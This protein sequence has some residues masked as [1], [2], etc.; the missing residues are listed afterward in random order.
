[1]HN[2]VSLLQYDCL[3]RLMDAALC[4]RGPE[5]RMLYSWHEQLSP[6]R[7]CAEEWLRCCPHELQRLWASS[8][9]RGLDDQQL[10]KVPKCSD[11][12]KMVST[13]FHA[14]PQDPSIYTALMP[15]FESVRILK[16]ERVEN[17][18]QEDVED[19]YY[20][21]LKKSLEKQ[22]VEFEPGMHTRWLFH[23]TDAIESIISNPL[24]GFQPL[25]SGGR[26][27][28]VWGSGT[29]FARDAE[30][31]HHGHFCKPRA[32]G[33]RQMLMC[34][35]MTGIPCLGG[36]HQKGVLPFRHKPY[37]YNSAVDSLSNPEIFIVQHPSAAYPAYL[38]T[39]A[40]R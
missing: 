35:V 29:Y 6:E 32:D 39:Y 38:I 33:S 14:E 16:V 31:V 13:I 30:Y 11:E 24:A 3:P 20:M 22:G 7:Q 10:F 37:R 4:H 28:S 9:H 18:L 36:E 1:M 15:G 34:L 25:T 27:G 23:G 8:R 19:H 12:F 5:A 2:M 40:D 17:G 21:A 26:L